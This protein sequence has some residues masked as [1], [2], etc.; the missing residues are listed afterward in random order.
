VAAKS[1]AEC[2]HSDPMAI[3]CFHQ[4]PILWNS[5]LA[6]KICQKF[7]FVLTDQISSLS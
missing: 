4:G 5:V 3:V 7:H 1:T 2:R 6:T